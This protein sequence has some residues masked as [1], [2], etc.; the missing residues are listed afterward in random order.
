[1]NLK[2]P[3]K[4]KPTP[5]PAELVKDLR[6]GKYCIIPAKDFSGNIF[7]KGSTFYEVQNNASWKRVAEPDL[8]ENTLT[9]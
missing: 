8:E 7:K 3:P 4:W 1:M 6:Q 5:K 2:Y 9:I